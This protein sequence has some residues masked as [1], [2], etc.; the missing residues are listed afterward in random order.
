MLIE[1]SMLRIVLDHWAKWTERNDFFHDQLQDI[2]CSH[3]VDDDRDNFLNLHVPSIPSLR[4]VD[5]YE[6]KCH[7]IE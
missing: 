2:H 7:T 6:N 1:S 4:T 3:S 5:E